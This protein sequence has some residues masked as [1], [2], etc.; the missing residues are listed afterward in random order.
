MGYQED[1]PRHNHNLKSD[2]EEALAEKTSHS[3]LNNT[4]PDLGWDGPTDP[5]RPVN[6]SKK[7][8]WLNMFSIGYLTFLT[9][10]TSSIVAPAQ[11]L[12]LKEFH[13]TNKTLS[14][15]VVSIYLVGFA[16][17][18]LFL[19]PLSEMYGRL[20]IYQIGTMIFV[21]WNV[22]CA[23][24]PSIGA[25]LAFRLFAGISGSSP[26]TLGA[27]S[28]ADMFV[29]EERGAALSIYGLGPLMGPVIGPIAGGYL[30]QAQG[31]RW[32]F[33]L[34]AIVSGVAVIIVSIL[35]S[36][37]Y[38][39]VLLRRRATRIRKE[40]GHPH[41]ISGQDL[42][43]DSRKTFIQAISRP[44]KILLLTPN[45]ALFSLYTGIVFGYLYLLFT[46]V[47]DVY[48]TT[49]NFSQGATGLVFIGIGVGSLIGLIFFGALSDKIQNHLIAKNNGQAEPEF[50]LPI[51]ILAS[52]LV[53][54]GLFWYGWSAHMNAHW[55][56]PIIGLG[57]IG[58]GIIATLMPIQA[59][60][61][62]AFGEYAASA[63]AANTVVRSVVGA[64]LPLAG[65]SMYAT[66]G[67]G[68]GNSLLGF[69]A[70]CMLPVPVVFYIYGKRIRM[71]PRSQISL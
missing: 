31:W 47:T 23:L 5:A 53:P 43:V 69:I 30:S 21:V 17:G 64:F 2:D 27:G 54:I 26:V 12:V 38:E 28:V 20:R 65:P 66:L 25:L 11:G 6:W 44:T 56:M 10:L 36:E 70:L 63:V 8:K 51:L 33:W 45:A 46:T 4:T 71:S 55:I 29:R 57:W 67:Q 52:F 61:V 59:Y 58:C 1:L 42:K 16:I 34:L 62:D 41:I 60:L 24:S 19:A 22:A 49:Y 48:Q 35:Q 7:K 32:V 39:P 9:P 37:T 40:M 15:F 50:R 18:P 3:P 14:S 13:T 68:W